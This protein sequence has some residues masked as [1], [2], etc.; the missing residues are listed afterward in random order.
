MG[1]VRA[2]TS[3]PATAAGSLLSRGSMQRYASR[4]SSSDASAMTSRSR[5]ILS[6]D[7]GGAGGVAPITEGH[8]QV[9]SS[10]EC[11]EKVVSVVHTD[12]G[13]VMG[14]LDV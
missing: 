4:R 8:V 2:P 11:G 10:V 9:V 1:T 6:V 3:P 14:E 5:S 13:G 12:D 7:G